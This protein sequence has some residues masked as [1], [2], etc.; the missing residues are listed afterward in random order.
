MRLD[1]RIFHPS[2]T[3]FVGANVTICPCPPDV[4]VIAEKPVSVLWKILFDQPGIQIATILFSIVEDV[5][6]G[7]KAWIC[8][9]TAHTNPAICLN[10]KQLLAD[11]KSLVCPF[12]GRLF[13]G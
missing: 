13:T 7:E 9:P 10:N 4:A 5:V 2:K 8:F 3:I 12:Q 11:P 6:D 1:S